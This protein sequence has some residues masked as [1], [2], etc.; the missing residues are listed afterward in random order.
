VPLNK[1]PTILLQLILGFSLILILVISI[2]SYFS[3][4][5]SSQ[6]VLKKTTH[7]LLESVVQMRGKTDVMLREYDKLSQMIAFSPTIQQ[8][9]R[10]IQLHGKNN[11]GAAEINRFMADQCRYMG[12]DFLIIDLHGD[13]YSCHKLLAFYWKT[14]DEI[15]RLSWYPLLLENNRGRVLWLSGFA[16]RNGKIPAVIGARQL[17]H[18]SSLKKLGDMYMVFPVELLD[19]LIEEKN[20]DPS[21]KIHVIDQLGRVVYSS[22]QDEVGQIVDE[23]LLKE[24]SKG[25]TNIINWDLRDTPTYISYSVSDYSGWTVAAYIEAD[26]AVKDLKKIQKSIVIIGIFGLAAS[27]LLTTFFSW[28]LARP[29]RYLAMRLGRVECGILTP[30]RGRMVNCEVATLY[31]SFNSMVQNLDKTIKDLSDKQISEEQAQLVALKAQFNPHFL[32]NSL[33]TIYWSLLNEGQE[34]V[35]KMVLTLSDLLRYSIQPGSEMVTVQEDLD[36]LKR[37]VVLQKAR[38]GEKLQMEI[39]LEPGLTH[40]R[41]MKLLLQPIVE[42][43]ITHGLE[44]VKDRPWMILVDIRRKEENIYFIVE[45]NG[46][47]LLEE[48][49]ERVLN[50]RRDTDEQNM[51]HSGL[52]LANLHYRIGL[53]YGKEY[54]IQLSKGMLGGLRVEIVVPATGGIQNGPKSGKDFI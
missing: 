15:K 39:H 46:K 24:F 14:Q 2:T 26:G 13:A 4:R 6:I 18:W 50:F 53:I 47:G 48:E 19:R 52:G 35:A 9:L 25:K 42:N 41:M 34:K 44:S 28:S 5:Y 51:M 30:Y 54:G 22:R 45:D 36:Q 27:L 17:N 32:Y 8:Y 12:T 16:W 38:Y 29:I 11:A 33:N 7:Y 3:Y 37:F 40:C 10:N 21:R 43:A 1:K 23:N 31:E 49:M 20:L